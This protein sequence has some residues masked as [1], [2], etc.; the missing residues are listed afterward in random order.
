MAGSPGAGKT[1][2]SKRL[3]EDFS[4]KPIRIDADEIRAFCPG[5]TGD[6]AFVFQKAAS[7]GVHLLYD[8]A[9]KNGMNVILDGTFAYVGVADN[10]ARSLE[11]GRKVEVYYVWQEPK[12]AW[13]LVVAR[14]AIEHRKVTRDFFAHALVAARQNIEQMKQRF[15]DRIELN[16][17]MKDYDSKDERVELDIPSIDP[18][19]PRRYS[20]TD[21]LALIAP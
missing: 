14:E 21:I 7:K 20:E 2:T 10:V 19:L 1:E 15:G 4:S 11:H 8:H 6:K 9:L 13:E 16:L 17:I 12:R 18:Y 5:Y 3:V